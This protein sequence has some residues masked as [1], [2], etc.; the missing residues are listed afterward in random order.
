MARKLLNPYQ[1]WL[2]RSREDRFQ[3][4][5]EEVM[6]GKPLA[7]TARFLELSRSQLYVKV[8]AARAAKADAQERSEATSEAKAGSDGTAVMGPVFEKRRVPDFWEFDRL[9]FSGLVCPDCGVHHE[10]PDF[11]KAI[12]D[13]CYGPSRRDLINVPPY[14]SKSTLVTLKTTIHQLVENP[15]GRHLIVSASQPFAKTFITGLQSWFRNPDVYANSPRNLIEDWGPFEGPNWTST[16]M[17]MAGRSTADQHPSVLAVGVGN[18]IYGRR[19]DRIIFDDCA[20]LDNQR[21]PEQVTKML[22]WI[23]KEALSRVGKTSKAIFV[24]TRISAG[25]IYSHLQMIEGFNVVRFPCIIDEE[26]QQTVWSDHF[27]FDMARVRRAE[28]RPEDWQLVYQNVDTPG[29]G[30]AFPAE[31]LETCLDTSRVHGQYDPKW[32][33]VIGL[34]PAGGGK[35]SGFTSMVLLGLDPDEQMIHLVDVVNVRAMKAFQMRDQILDWCNQYPIVELRTEVN[36]IQGQLIQYNHDLL[37]PLTAKGVRVVPHYTTGK[38]WDPQFGVEAIAPWF[39]NRR[40]SIPWGSGPTQHRFRPLLDQFIGFPMNI[41]NQPTDLVMAFWFAWLAC[42]Q[43]TEVVSGPLYGPKNLPKFVRNRR[44]VSDP[45]TGAL[46]R[47]NDRNMP[48]FGRVDP[49]RPAKQSRPLVNMP[50]VAVY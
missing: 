16:Q 44:R 26:A 33:L 12:I 21:N 45:A 17:Y 4:A 23:S 19:A 37:L 10:T 46:W 8:N 50:G 28:M 18:Q 48:D 11:H 42:K 34:D 3:H 31:V 22:E 25:D 1:T 38:K 20:T 29:V 27:P 7:T 14:H 43:Q 2:R 24:G 47:P 9:Y 15:N 5:V 36:G 40:I 32:K 6:A 13:A 39:Y 35:Q 30:S 41:G 49:D